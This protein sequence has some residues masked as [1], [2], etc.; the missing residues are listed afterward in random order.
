MC[1]FMALFAGCAE[2]KDGPVN[3]KLEGKLSKNV[4]FRVHDDNSKIWL[5]NSH[6]EKISVETDGEGQKTLVFTTTEEGKTVLYNATTENI[7]KHLSVSAD[8]YLLCSA[9]VMAA[10]EDGRFTFNRKFIDHTYLYNYLTGAK[11]IMKGVTPPDD[12]IS[13]DTAKDKAFERA[14]TTADKVSQ[15]SIGLLIDPDFFGWI[16]SIDFT[17][18]NHEY[19]TEVNAHTGGI[20]K[21][22]F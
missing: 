21:F 13:E 11:D 19:T 9:E 12:L 5:D 10:I 18:D 17:V 14:G 8:K 1:L 20:T 4:E 15:L 6:I 22:I 3:N 2:K 16:Y 7:G